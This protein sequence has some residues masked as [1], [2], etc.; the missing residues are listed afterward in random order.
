MYQPVLEAQS[1]Q[2]ILGNHVAREPLPDSDTDLV[3]EQLG[4]VIDV[5]SVAVDHIPSSRM[6]LRTGLMQLRAETAAQSAA[7][8]Q[9]RCDTDLQA[10]GHKLSAEA[11]LFPFL[12]P[13]GA[14]LHTQLWPLC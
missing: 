2:T 5:N 6:P 4:L 9:L 7:K 13:H 10:V 14:I 8:F 1:V 11:A 3:N 12:F